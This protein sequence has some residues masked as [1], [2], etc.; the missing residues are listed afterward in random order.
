MTKA[1][2]AAAVCNLILPLRA[3]MTMDSAM[4]DFIEGEAKAV[5]KL[6]ISTA[7]RILPANYLSSLLEINSFMISLVPP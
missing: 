1:N 6:K 5:N 7:H 4:D 2:K 3:G